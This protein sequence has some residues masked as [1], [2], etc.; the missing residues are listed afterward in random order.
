[1]HPAPFSTTLPA[2]LRSLAAHR[3]A[4]IALLGVDDD[5]DDA[6]VCVPRARV[7]DADLIAIEHRRGRAKVAAR[8]LMLGGC[9]G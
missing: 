1:M 4:L 7:D 9:C 5:L 3:A 6:A 2:P 8:K